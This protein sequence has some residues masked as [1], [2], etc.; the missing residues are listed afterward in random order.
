MA[1]D[2]FIFIH[3]SIHL[4]TGKEKDVKMLLIYL[5]LA[6]FSSYV[7]ED[8]NNIY[9]QFKSIIFVEFLLKKTQL[10]REKWATYIHRKKSKYLLTTKN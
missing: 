7:N 1:L 4:S 10:N 3:S 2:I 9:G 8:S 6:P 5:F